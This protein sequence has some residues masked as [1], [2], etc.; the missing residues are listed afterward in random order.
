M[1]LFILRHPVSY[2]KTY[3]N[4]NNLFII[5]NILLVRLLLFKIMIF[6]YWYEICIF[7]DNYIDNYDHD[8]FQNFILK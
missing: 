4:N 2:N 3:D 1:G 5:D 7:F 8:L 6:S